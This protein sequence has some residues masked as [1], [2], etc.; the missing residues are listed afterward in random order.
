MCLT[1]DKLTKIKVMLSK[2]MAI[3]SQ[4]LIYK[5]MKLL[6]PRVNQTLF[7]RPVLEIF[8]NMFTQYIKQLS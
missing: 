4:N 5:T 1:I 3:I 2:K 8:K 6:S 7:D